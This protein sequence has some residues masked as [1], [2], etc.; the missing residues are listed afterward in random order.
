MPT[1]VPTVV[2]TVLL[3]T[4]VLPTRLLPTHVPTRLLPTH[5]PTHALPTRARLPREL[6]TPLLPPALPPQHPQRLHTCGGHLASPGRHDPFAGL[7][8]G[9]RS[10]GLSSEFRSSP[11]TQLAG[12]PGS[13]ASPPSPP[14]LLEAPET[15]HPCSGASPPAAPTLLEAPLEAP[16]TY[17]P[18]CRTCP[19][20]T[21]MP[22]VP[23]PASPSCPPVLYSPS[24]PGH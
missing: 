7:R 17:R 23:S 14:T 1:V 6:R 13:G 21:P 18:R 3:P 24:Q 22:T 12:P 16:A 9:R 2:P 15:G 4:G 10:V 8:T 5:V 20:G 19:R 11:P